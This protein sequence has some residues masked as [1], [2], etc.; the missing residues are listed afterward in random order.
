M[1][2]RLLLPLAVLM[3][4]AACGG[5]PSTTEQPQQPQ[6]PPAACLGLDA[7]GCGLVL[8]AV[9]AA[10]GDDLRAVSYVQVGPFSCLDEACPPGLAARPAGDVTVEFTDRNPVVLAAVAPGGVVNL[11]RRGDTFLVAVKPSSPP[12]D[13]L[14]TPYQLAHCGIFSGVDVD[15]AFWDPVGIVDADHSDFIN[16]AEGTFTLTSAR[17]ATLRTRG[18][19]SL[20]LIRHDGVK[21]LPGCM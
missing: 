3:L 14:A 16:S 7:G 5:R 10:L 6:R 2:A 19:L 20:D 8:D 9:M 17:T 13:G 21:H 12:L 18:G 15:G 1:T 11:T 4:M